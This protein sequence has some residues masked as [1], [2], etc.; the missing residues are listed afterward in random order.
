[1]NLLVHLLQKALAHD[2]LKLGLV[3]EAGRDLFVLLHA[4]DKE[5][6]KRS[7]KNISIAPH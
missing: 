2:P 1:M 3:K 6:L 7:E 5:A 4:I